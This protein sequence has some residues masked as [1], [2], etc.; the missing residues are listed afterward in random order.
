MRVSAKI[1]LAYLAVLLLAVVAGDLL[2][3]RFLENL[4]LTNARQDLQ[5]EW[6]EAAPGLQGAVLAPSR[7]KALGE[8]LEKFAAGSPYRFTLFD[9]AGNRVADTG[10]EASMGSDA[11]AAPPEVKQAL[12]SG[13]AFALRAV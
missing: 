9:L 8:R 6:F 11:A 5:Q 3:V 1:F 4:L 2:L 12:D 13:Q 7:A 10:P